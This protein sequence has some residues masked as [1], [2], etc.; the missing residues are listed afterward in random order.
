MLGIAGRSAVAFL[1]ALTLLRLA[2]RK[3]ISQLNFLDF[4]L[5]NLTG[6][7]LG[8]YAVG[9]AKGARVFVACCVH[10]LGHSHGT[11]DTEEPSIEKNPRGATFNGDQK[12]EDN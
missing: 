3:S 6:N 10:C 11:V 2:G 4:L 7:I 12:W 9:P 5:A 8:N 1:C